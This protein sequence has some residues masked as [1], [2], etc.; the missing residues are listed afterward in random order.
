[1]SETDTVMVAQVGSYGLCSFRIAD[2]PGEPMMGVGVWP[3]NRTGLDR[4][5]PKSIKWLRPSLLAVML[6]QE[7]SDGSSGDEN[8]GRGLERA[9]EALR[10]V[11]YLEEERARRSFPVYIV[12]NK[13]DLVLKKLLQGGAAPPRVAALKDD[14]HERVFELFGYF[15]ASGR[16]GTASVDEA[17]AHV[18][19]DP[20]LTQ[21][22][23]TRKLLR[24]TLERWRNVLDELRENGFLN[25]TL[26]FASSLSG[27][28]DP[29]VKPGVKAFW[30]HL[31]ERTAPLFSAALDDCA[32]RIFIDEMEDVS[33]KV[34]ARLDRATGLRLPRIPTVTSDD[35]VD[36]LE[37]LPDRA[38]TVKGKIEG[39]YGP[40][41]PGKFRNWFG[42]L[43]PV[44]NHVLSIADRIEEQVTV[45]STEWDTRLRRA[46]LELNVPPNKVCSAFQSRVENDETAEELEIARRQPGRAIYLGALQESATCRNEKP[47]WWIDDS[48]GAWVRGGG[49]MSIEERVRSRIDEMCREDVVG[50]SQ[51][52]DGEP[53]ESED[54]AWPKEGHRLVPNAL[55]A[56]ADYGFHDGDLRDSESPDYR[57][58][59]VT[60]Y[61][62]DRF[63]VEA[64]TQVEFRKKIRERI[65]MAVELVERLARV[66]CYLVAG[67]AEAEGS[68]LGS[69]VR[70]ALL[71][72]ACG[73][74]LHAM[75]FDV[76]KMKRNEKEDVREAIEDS[77]ENVMKL[78]DKVNKRSMKDRVANALGRG[79][80]FASE[81][82][83]RGEEGGDDVLQEREGHQGRSGGREEGARSPLVRQ[84]SH[85]GRRGVAARHEERAV[86]ERCD[87]R[88]VAT[89]R[90]S[91]R[92]LRRGRAGI[93]PAGSEGLVVGAL[94]PS[95]VAPDTSRGRR[96]SKS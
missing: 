34:I 31:W 94:A 12:M 55:Y 18:S 20:D 54:R 45:F 7:I 29:N 72:F 63:R 38:G 6:S 93:R 92:T 67:G 75:G 76:E 56:I 39:N 91:P 70:G 81:L 84:G 50:V 11:G 83:D 71:G 15:T 14:L 47:T 44:C 86:D 2:L 82:G 35:V 22:I 19:D 42:E 33:R 41:T 78:D 88:R 28:T 79:A 60:L 37:R 61:D 32:R 52:F 13:S 57:Y 74:V 58:L 77:C 87:S 65:H 69:F 1:M 8:I 21:N 16:V 9:L 25:I 53:R 5:L 80:N 30:R 4:E 43:D 23:A 46:L 48:A 95:G 68:R 40:D 10:N 3:E 96:D 73:H 59:T 26:V 49:Q 85:R 89:V 66:R 17:L 90:W 24:N 64:L 62:S 27:A 36:S 51:F